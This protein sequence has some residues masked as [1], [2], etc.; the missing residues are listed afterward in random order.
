MHLR[1]PMPSTGQALDQPVY[2]GLVVGRPGGDEA[3]HMLVYKGA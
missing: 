1:K 2:V 3:D